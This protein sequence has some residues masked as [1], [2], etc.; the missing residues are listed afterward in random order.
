MGKRRKDIGVPKPTKRARKHNSSMTHPAFISV[1]KFLNPIEKCRLLTLDKRT[2]LS[3]LGPYME[4]EHMQ[5][6]MIITS[7]CWTIDSHRAAWGEQSVP[8]TW[9]HFLVM[10]YREGSKL[11]SEQEMK[12]EQWTWRRRSDPQLDLLV[13]RWR[14]LCPSW[15]EGRNDS[16]CDEYIQDV[17]VYEL[18][19]GDMLSLVNRAPKILIDQVV[20]SMLPSVLW[21]TYYQCDVPLSRFLRLLKMRK[22]HKWPAVLQ[23]SAL[24]QE[25]ARMD[26]YGIC[27][28]EDGPL[29]RE[30]LA[31]LLSPVVVRLLL[32]QPDFV[33][34]IDGMLPEDLFKCIQHFRPHDP[35]SHEVLGYNVKNLLCARSAVFS[36]DLTDFWDLTQP[37]GSDSAINIEAECQPRCGDMYR[38]GLKFMQRA[39]ERLTEKVQ[40]HLNSL[41]LKPFNLNQEQ[42]PKYITSEHRGPFGVLELSLTEADAGRNEQVNTNDHEGEVCIMTCGISSAVLYRRHNNHC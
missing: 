5:Q 7:G 19:S 28:S 24:E 25:E 1:F 26:D 20:K 22:S 10:L 29:E 40:R 8:K 3:I 36:L 18:V 41:D 14:Y 15:Q 42:W 6:C 16:Q 27:E 35:D 32:T 12:F 21:P 11:A 34:K 30:V 39:E 31:L 33:M 9:L 2:H 23:W 37:I 38:R 13:N 4:Y 17:G